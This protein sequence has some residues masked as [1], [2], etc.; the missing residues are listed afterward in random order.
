MKNKLLLLLLLT[1]TLLHAQPFTEY[2][3]TWATFFGCGTF[4]GGYNYAQD[5][6]GNLYFAVDLSQ[7]TVAHTPE[8]VMHFNQFVLPLNTNSEYRSQNSQGI[9]VKISP[10]GQVLQASYL[11]FRID[12]LTINNNNEIFATGSTT[13]TTLATPG[14][15]AQTPFV[16]NVNDNNYYILAKLNPNFTT[17]W[18]SY[19]P[20][21][22]FLHIKIDVQNN[23]YFGGNTKVTSGITTTNAHQQ[24]F[25]NYPNS[26]GN[27]YLAKFNNQGQLVWATYYDKTMG[28]NNMHILG[29]E[30]VFAHFI[31]NTSTFTTTPNAYHTTPT[32]NLISKFNIHSGARTYASYLNINHYDIFDTTTDGTNI[33]LLSAVNTQ[34]L[35]NNTLFISPQAYQTQLS[36]SSDYYILKLDHNL[37]PVWATLFGGSGV[38]SEVMI[39]TLSYFENALYFTGYSENM[40]YINPEKENSL[41]HFVAKFNTNGNFLTA[42]DLDI[43]NYSYAVQLSPLTDNSFYVIAST[44]YAPNMATPNAHQSDFIRNPLFGNTSYDGAFISL[45]SPVSYLSTPS[46]QDTKTKIYPNPTTNVVTISNPENIKNVNVYTMLGQKI[47]TKSLNNGQLNISHLPAGNYII[48]LEFTNHKIE[49]HKIIKL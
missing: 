15:F 28:Y 33:Y 6:A 30:L 17:N 4:G 19:I 32:N 47:P 36:G 40:G 2:Q 35:S 22:D 41:G 21:Y 49:H 37:E 26:A 7:T 20:T 11:P 45:Y 1:T 14:T 34:E 46:F 23:I 44:K 29:D 24:H 42:L 18:L 38:E 10:Q 12:N 5:N 13:H 9:L 43:P 39:N 25:I 48:S 8:V 31:S 27:G 16:T 3:K